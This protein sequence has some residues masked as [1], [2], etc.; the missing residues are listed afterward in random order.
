MLAEF[1]QIS[2]GH[3]AALISMG[4][5]EDTPQPPQRNGPE[6]PDDMAPLYAKY[7]RLRFGR[8]VDADAVTLV[9]RAALQYAE[10]QAYSQISGDAFTPLEADII[11]SID[12]IF[13]GSEHG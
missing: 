7:K 11:M 13:E 9:P 6:M 10:L 8:K 1:D 5:I 3:K 12:A 2:A 4:V